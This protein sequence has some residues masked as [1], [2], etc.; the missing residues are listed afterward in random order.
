LAAAV[1]G[2]TLASNVEVLDASRLMNADY[3]SKNLSIGSNGV[4]QGMVQA[5]QLLLLSGNSG[6]NTIV[7]GEGVDYLMG[8]GVGRAGDAGVRWLPQL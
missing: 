3:T 5:N 4:T 8:G 2:Y 1:S 6:S 7:G